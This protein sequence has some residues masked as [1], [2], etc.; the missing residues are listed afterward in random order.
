MV[1]GGRIFLSYRREDAGHAGRLQDALNERLGADHV[2]LDIEIRPGFNFV[3][4]IRNQIANADVFIAMIGPRWLTAGDSDG[5]R[6]INQTDD[7]VRVEL[8]EAIAAG[9]VVIPVLIGGA[10]MPAPSELPTDI[11]GLASFQPVELRE[12]SWRQDAETLVEA[13]ATARSA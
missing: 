5:R 10:K 13:L 1:K 9:T 11:A 2:V 7:F 3:D 12:T 6:R 4:T 8:A